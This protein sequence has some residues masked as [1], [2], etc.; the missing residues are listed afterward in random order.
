MDVVDVADDHGG[1]FG[2]AGRG[3][4]LQEAGS[5]EAAVNVRH[6]GLDELAELELLAA[7]ADLDRAQFAGPVVD[8]LKEVAM[9]R[10]QMGEVEG[11]TRNRLARIRKATSARSCLS[12]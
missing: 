6:A 8:V 2:E 11:A 7:L 5:R 9:D 3:Q 10:A 1:L 4:S 12:R